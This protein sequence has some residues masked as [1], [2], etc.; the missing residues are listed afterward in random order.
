MLALRFFSF[1][2]VLFIQLIPEHSNAQSSKKRYYF[3]QDLSIFL[4]TISIYLLKKIGDE[5]KPCGRPLPSGHPFI[6]VEK[7][8][9][10]SVSITYFSTFYFLSIRNRVL[11]S[12]LSNA[13]EQSINNVAAELIFFGCYCLYILMSVINLSKFTPQSNPCSPPI[14]AG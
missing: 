1:L 2:T 6:N 13:D 5:R 4:T 8:S 12:T 7:Y 11:H 14:W 10:F 9:I 3:K